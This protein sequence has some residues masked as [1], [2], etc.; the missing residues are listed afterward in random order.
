VDGDVGQASSFPYFAFIIMFVSILVWLWLVRPRFC[1]EI[2][3]RRG[4]TMLTIEV[5]F[6]FDGPDCHPLCVHEVFFK[7]QSCQCG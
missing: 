2:S 5:P 4:T 6:I 7:A 1:V 3:R